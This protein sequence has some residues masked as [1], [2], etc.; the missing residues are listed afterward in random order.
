MVTIK[1]VLEG[2][3][4]DIKSQVNS[5]I[6]RAEEL[7]SAGEEFGTDM[8]K[9]KNHI[10][11]AK[12]QLEALK[13]KESLA[14]AKKAETEGESA[15][16]T[17]LQEQVRETRDS[18][19][20]T[21]SIKEDV[22]IPQQLLD[23]AQN[24]LK[25]K[26]YI[27]ALHALNSARERSR[28]IQFNT[29]LEVI[30]QAR[31][32]FVLAKK[33]GVDM[34]KAITLLNTSRD[35]LKLG[36]FQ[37]AMDY[38]EQ[39]K[40]EVDTSLEMFYKARDQMTELAKAVKFAAISGGRVTGQEQALGREE[41][42]RGQGLR[43]HRGSH[44]GRHQRGE[45][46]RTPEGHGDDR[47]VRR[48]GQARKTIGADITEAEGT[49]QRALDYMTKE[50]LTESVNLARSSYEA[51]NAAMTRVM[52]D[53]LQNIDSFVKGYS[54]GTDLSEVTDMITSARQSIATFD[55]SKRMRLSVKSPLTSSP[56]GKE[57][58]TDS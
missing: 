4:E 17:K 43:Q 14:Y 22:T 38:A 33:V 23:Q 57:S 8:T 9:V 36:R 48:G 47:C 46:A 54:S 15:I 7:V 41:V 1:E 10:E 49:L 39:S 26:K 25:E 16:S 3:G 30:A 13:F 40:K 19:K 20:K 44:E 53:K 42:L 6:S 51:S 11:R 50:D 2:A 21:K 55:F 45:E 31:D 5:T 34:T 28:D 32:R 24:A 52:S 27:E 58:A 35:N 12:S 37:D 56:S 18:I 29:V